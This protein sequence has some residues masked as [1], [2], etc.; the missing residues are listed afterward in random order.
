MRTKLDRLAALPEFRLKAARLG[1]LI[2]ALVDA[3]LARHAKR[4][5]RPARSAAPSTTR[6]VPQWVREAVIERDGGRCAYVAA[7]G[8]RCEA[9]RWLQF[10]H[11]K[12]WA[13]GGPSD[14]PAN[15]RLLCRAH[16]LMLA[17][18]L[19]PAAR[20]AAERPAPAG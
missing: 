12:P 18:R 20:R 16:N 17:R 14:D 4:K 6:R 11:V 7:D 19:F 10:D 8:T 2:E 3:A 9:R 5:A 13:L 1:E 15:I